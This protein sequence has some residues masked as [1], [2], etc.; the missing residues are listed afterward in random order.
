L[1][2]AADAGDVT[3]QADAAAI[4]LQLAL[5]RLHPPLR[6]RFPRPRFRRA[7]SVRRDEAADTPL[8]RDV[9]EL[10]EALSERLSLIEAYVVARAVGSTPSELAWLRSVL[11]R[12]SWAG[13]AKARVVRDASIVLEEPTVE[14]AALSVADLIFR[15][16]AAGSFRPTDQWDL[17]LPPPPPAGDPE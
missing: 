7:T 15:M 13:S 12:P 6:P 4:A 9:V 14:R 2:Q 8:R 3:A 11:G 10:E 16:W 17:P 1:I 5:A